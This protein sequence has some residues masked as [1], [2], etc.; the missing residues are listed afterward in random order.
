MLASLSIVS[1]EQST[2]NQASHTSFSWLKTFPLGHRKNTS[3]LSTLTVPPNQNGPIQSN[4]I[5]PR[6]FRTRVEDIHRTKSRE[7][8]SARSP[9][10]YGACTATWTYARNPLPIRM[11]SSSRISRKSEC[12][13]EEAERL[14]G[15]S[16]TASSVGSLDTERD[17]V[18]SA[19]SEERVISWEDYKEV[20][21]RE[22]VIC[23]AFLRFVVLICQT[24]LESSIPPIM[25]RFFDHGDL[26]NSVVYLIAGIELIT[27]CSLLSVFTKYVSD[28]ILVSIGL[29]LMLASLVWLGVVIPSL[30]E[31]DRSTLPFFAI[32]IMLEFMGISIICYVGLSLYSKLIPDHM[33]GF[34]HATR[35]FI[36]QFAILL[37][38]LWGTGT[39]D[40]PNISVV[41]PILILL[42]GI[43]MYLVSFQRMIPEARNMEYD[44][45]ADED[46]NDG[47]NREP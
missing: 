24:S 22:E 21:L 2:L 35:R 42:P 45:I 7:S 31:H 4:N 37:G 3:Y 14:M 8:L 20:L 11:R 9:R 15:E 16:E 34:S 12:F 17:T 10:N 18:T 47:E 26:A 28:R 38:P 41:V 43:V 19:D 33:Q 46:E 44:V 5:L 30:V 25:E 39:I 13:I 40:F 1:V 36:S 29:I 23:L 27:I 32:G 6:A